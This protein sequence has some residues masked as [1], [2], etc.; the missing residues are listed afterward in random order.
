MSIKSKKI[1]NLL[2]TG[3]TSGIGL[4]IIRKLA[5]QN[6]NILT[7]ARSKKKLVQIKKEF[8]EIKIFKC[9]ISKE[10]NVKKLFDFS[11]KNF[12]SI[13]IIINTAGIYGEIEK[14]ENSN[15]KIW[16]KAIEVNFFGTYLICKYFIPLL[17]A[18]KIKKIINFSG[19]GAF[20]S[21]PNYSAYASSKA[22]LVRFSETLASELKKEKIAV[23]CI[24]PG[25][26]T[27]PLHEATIAAGV[28]K[29]GKEFLNFTK[30]KLKKGSVPIE[31]P[32]KCVEFLISSKSKNL[33]GKTISASFDKWHSKKFQTEISNYNK[34]DI[35]TMRRVNL[36]K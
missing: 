4:E 7:C 23:N 19:G 11:K 3:G 35:F 10:S 25:F 16:K 9:D 24:A 5:D 1:K 14:I 18:S 17:K 22:A 29:A 31:L 8:K 26:V 12:K 27:T 15:F 28:G 30:Q 32:V 20:N 2:I 21:F 13:D 33:T 36:Q 34:T 6:V